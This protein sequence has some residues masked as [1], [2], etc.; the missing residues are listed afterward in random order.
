MNIV[1]Y[2]QRVDVA[3]SYGERR[4][5]ADQMI[6]K[7]LRRCGVL[8]MPVPNVPQLVDEIIS[9]IDPR[10]IFLSGGN[11]LGSAPER[12]Q[13][14]K[15]LLDWAIENARPVFGICRGM[16]FI[17]NYFGTD[18]STVENHVRTRH[19]ISGVINRNA[20]NS[21]HNFGLIEVPECFDVLGRADDHSIE[22]IRHK[23][24]KIAAVGWHPE[25]EAPFDADDI[26]MI[27]NFF[28][29]VGI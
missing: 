13:T 27:K 23:K 11:D 25:R 16:Q 6:P 26:Y 14:E 12:D 8:P 18:L 22:S 2:S 4:D 17:A 3:A 5:C 15:I 19:K 20:V 28:S 24:F 9:A 21:F 7:F 29:G 10:G 1:L